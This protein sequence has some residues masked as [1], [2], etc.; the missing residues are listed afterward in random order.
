MT[1]DEQEQGKKQRPKI[2]GI[3]QYATLGG[4]KTSKHQDVQTSDSSSVQ[5]TSILD[6]QTSKLPDVQKPRRIR[7]TVYL[8]PEN[9]EWIRDSINAA[10]KRIGKR[11]EISDLVNEALRRMREHE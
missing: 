3:S 10:R 9:D 4:A 1:E 2:G 11:F 7:Q 8:E 6:V 5:D